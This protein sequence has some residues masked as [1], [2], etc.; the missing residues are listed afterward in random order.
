EIRL[1]P[2]DVGTVELIVRRPAENERETLT[3]AHLD[4][5]EGLV[6]DG[7][8]ADDGDARRQVTV[9]NARV[10]SLLA[11]S[12]DRWPLAGDQLYVDLDL[13]VENL[14]AGTR[15]EV[16][17]AVLEVSDEPHRGCKKFAARYGLDALRF[18]NSKVGY[19]LNLRGINT[20]VV[21]GGV[22]RPGDAVR[23]LKDS[24]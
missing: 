4:T 11:G 16:G 22:V 21:R 12:R 1:S 18:V 13:S 3:E 6:G 19:T 23:K 5:T 10:V 7:W 8:L 20:R 24:L 15:V 17:D 14:P 2:S 9:M